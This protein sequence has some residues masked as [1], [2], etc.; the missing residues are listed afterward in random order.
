MCTFPSTY[1]SES[2]PE[3]LIEIQKGLNKKH[4]EE[5]SKMIETTLNDNLGSPSIFAITEVVKEWLVDNNLPGKL[6][7]VSNIIFLIKI[8]RICLLTTM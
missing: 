4:M 1:P 8:E 7:F 6:Q 2:I 3:V 5:L